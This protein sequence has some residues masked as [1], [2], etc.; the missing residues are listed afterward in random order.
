MPPCWSP[1]PPCAPASR[2]IKLAA[3]PAFGQPAHC[4][5]PRPLQLVPM[6]P[7]ALR[8][9]VILSPVP[10]LPPGYLSQTGTIEAGGP[11]GFEDPRCVGEA[12]QD[13]RCGKEAPGSPAEACNLTMIPPRATHSVR[14]R[15]TLS[16]AQPLPPL[17]PSSLGF[18]IHKEV[19]GRT[20]GR[21]DVP[22][23]RR[24]KGTG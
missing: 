23:P 2:D 6:P 13:F 18:D 3:S 21:Q 22:A 8:N 1:D 7:G 19:V 17:P 12:Q 24:G 15:G 11:S 5:Q 16:C 4:P 10:P 9:P 20:T 14:P